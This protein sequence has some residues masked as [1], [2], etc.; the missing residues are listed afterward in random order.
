MGRF[1]C[2]FKRLAHS[3]TLYC[4]AKNR[5]CKENPGKV[6]K[7]VRIEAEKQALCPYRSISQKPPLSLRGAKRRGNLLV[8]RQ[9]SHCSGRRLPRFARNDSGGGKAV[10][11]IRMGNRQWWK[12]PA[13]CRKTPPFPGKR[14][15]LWTLISFLS[16][17]CPSGRISGP[18]GR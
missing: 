12:H 11:L 13:K 18:P 8:Q 15:A 10:L 9:I 2:R 5:P 14:G 6:Q 7:Y 16:G 3:F 1:I 17:W 4:T